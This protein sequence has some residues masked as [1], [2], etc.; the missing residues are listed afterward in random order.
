M[1]IGSIT[2]KGFRCFSDISTTVRL[3]EG[4][5]ALVG[6]NGTGKTALLEGLLRVFGITRDQRTIR[7]T[8]F[9][10]KPGTSED[11]RS[12][13]QLSIDIRLIFPELQE[14]S[15][16][17]HITIP[18]IFH[19]L[20]VEE[21]GGEPFVRLRLEAKWRDD[22]TM[23][24]EIEQKLCWVTTSSES[25]SNDEMRNC[26]PYERGLIQVHYVP[27]SRDPS[28]QLTYATTAMAGRLLRV[29]AWSS[30]TQKAV[31]E[32]S[33]QIREA[34]SSESVIQLFNQILT[35]RWGNLHD[36]LIDAE[37]EFNI[38]S[39]QF[40]EE[41][42]RVCVVFRP[43]EL[44][45]HRELDALSDGQKSLFYFSLA[46]AVFDIEKKLVQ[47][48]NASNSNKLTTQ[49]EDIELLSTDDQELSLETNFYSE[50]IQSPALTIFALEEPENHL[51]PYFLA[52]IIQLVRSLVDLQAAQALLTSHSSGVLGRISPSEVRHFRLNLTTRCASINEIRLPH[53]SE[54]SAKYI[55]EAV[56]VYPELYF[57]RFVILCEG[58]SEQVVLPRLASAM[59]L[60]VD[61]SFVAVVPLGGRH[62]NHFWKLLYDLDIPHATLLDL[63]KGRQGAGWGR[64]KYACKQL[65]AVGT[66]PDNLLIFLDESGNEIVT[67]EG[68]LERLHTRNEQDVEMND[69][70]RHLENFNVFFSEPLDLD[71]AMLSN[72]SD[73]YKSIVSPESGPRI[74]S[75]DSA[76][77]QSYLDTSGK[78]VLGEDT[79][80]STYSDELQQL[81]PWYRYLF[82]HKSKPSTHLQALSLIE[83]TDL[84]LNAPK[85]LIRLL[86]A[87]NQKLYSNKK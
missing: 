76:K 4:I 21:P 19:H 7:R 33:Q 20:R 68:D 58:D 9:Y 84:A 23:D 11:D 17:S 54:E 52:R 72:Y 39:K 34:F 75:I 50:R 53:A 79:S 82:L 60:E 38:A 36:D 64:I 78:A 49:E 56:S 45:D 16:D 27:A 13:R 15:T 40:E 29:I 74:P 5:T 1:K 41:I 35:Q 46:A 73:T 8:D 6:A 71:M 24:G 25:P 55:R 14:D 70:I 2:L 44:G 42:R 77:Y 10:V 67:S 66:E 57:A 62:V 87:V 51:A 47:Q 18:S 32:A 61:R 31:Q 43:T 83:N 48:S 37:P 26:E 28:T 30:E 3:S 65:L 86:Q 69:W 12:E 80:L 81:F 59:G 22:R 85:V 63:D